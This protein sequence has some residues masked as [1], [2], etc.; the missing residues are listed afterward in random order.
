MTAQ[1]IEC[2]RCGALRAPVSSE[3]RRDVGDC[4][5]CGYAGWAPSTELNEALRRLLRDRPPE[6]R[7]LR[8][9]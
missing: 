3:T 8:I 6:R 1:P 2:L 5:R 7:R 9:A 4:P